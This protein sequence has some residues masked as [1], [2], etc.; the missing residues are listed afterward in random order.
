MNLN[1]SG[2]AI[3]LIEFQNQWTKK[4]FYNRLIKKQLNSRNVLENTEKAVDNARKQGVRIIHAPLVIDPESKKGWLAHLTGGKVFTKGSDKS[5]ISKGLFQ[6]GDLIVKGRYAF[7]AFIGSDLCELLK[8]NN[9]ENVFICGFTTDQCVAK[10]MRTMIKKKI[11][12]YLVS[13]CTA[14]FNDFFQK[15]TE[16]KFADK[17]IN[18]REM[19]E[20]WNNDFYS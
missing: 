18:S 16:K 17:V 20:L 11:D 19:E 6:E 14:T 7:D 4:G 2:S 1:R 13:D 9:I 15:R 3:L 10:T 8:K 5:K 12:A